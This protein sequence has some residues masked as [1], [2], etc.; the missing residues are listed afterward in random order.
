[1]GS[2]GRAGVG[3]ERADGADM[4]A[5]MM[6]ARE[7]GVA[8]KSAVMICGA[9]HSGSTLLGMLLGR[10]DGAFYVGEGAKARYLGDMSKPLR[11]RACK[12]CGDDCPVWSG[13]TW[14]GEEPLYPLV[15]AHAGV[16][17]IVDSTKRP[18]WIE[19]RADETWASG[20]TPHLILLL[21]D[22]RAVVN[23]RIR[24]YP[25]RPVADLVEDWMRQMADSR[26]LFDAFR[27]PKLEVRYEA[28]AADPETVMSRVCDFAGL[29]YAP[30][31]LDIAGGEHHPLGGN[32]GT[33]FLATRDNGQASLVQP[34]ERSRT[35]YE[36]HGGSIRPDMR[37]K[38][39]LSAENAALF[40][41]MAGT[42][43][44]PCAWGNE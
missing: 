42:A 5:R 25:E 13:L 38:T 40:E 14:D 24:K 12:V 17:T 34:G 16:P 37:W 20:A 41:Q 28:L 39:E 4:A 32:N 33:Q 8:L 15:A 44:Q 9:G 21:R 22:G 1:M 23:S 29:T 7:P 27:G 31:M 30:A 26:A 10:A 2:D 6:P 36:Q 11:K 18:E 3:E 35:Y 43:N 19:A